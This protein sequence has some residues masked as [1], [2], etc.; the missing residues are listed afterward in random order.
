MIVFDLLT[1]EAVLFL[2]DVLL[3]AQWERLGCGRLRGHFDF[4]GGRLY[5]PL[6]T[7]PSQDAL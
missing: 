5:D 7:Q 2:G 4:A 6:G 1:F 3:L